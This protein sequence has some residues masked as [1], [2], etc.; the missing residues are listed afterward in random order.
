MHTSPRISES[1]FITACSIDIHDEKKI[2]EQNRIYLYAAVNLKWNLRSTYC[3]IEAIDRHEASRGLSATAGR[4]V[5]SVKQH[6]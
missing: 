1:M 3:T 5:V 6:K 4:L 2:R